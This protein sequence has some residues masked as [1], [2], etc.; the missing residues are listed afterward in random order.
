MLLLLNES[1]L[2]ICFH[3]NNHKKYHNQHRAQLSIFSSAT[4]H[5]RR[6][7]FLQVKTVVLRQG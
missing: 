5:M 3:S 2:P 6:I 1:C 7:Y 4:Q